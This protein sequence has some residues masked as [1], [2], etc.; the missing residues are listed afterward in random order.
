MPR[1]FVD[2]CVA[3]LI[4][5]GLRARGFDVLDAK[6]VCPGNTDER[7]LSLAALQAVW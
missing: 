1:F 3:S 7:A 5:D 2:E 4:A 6:D